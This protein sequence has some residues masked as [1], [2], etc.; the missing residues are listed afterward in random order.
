MF[1]RLMSRQTCETKI[2]QDQDAEW[3]QSGISD[4]KRDMPAG[5][6]VLIVHGRDNI[7]VYCRPCAYKRFD[8]EV[9]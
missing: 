1:V 8:M 7:E 6:P 9:Q 5:E 3:V 2:L 4:C